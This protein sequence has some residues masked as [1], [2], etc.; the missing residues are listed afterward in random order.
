MIFF[1]LKKKRNNEIKN[2]IDEIKQWEQKL[3]QNDLIYRA[4]KYK[5]KYF[6]QYDEA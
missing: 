2:E 6:Q 5:Y 3:K 1:F 4:N